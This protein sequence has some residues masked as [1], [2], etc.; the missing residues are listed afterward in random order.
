MKLTIGCMR[1]AYS[2]LHLEIDES[3]TYCRQTG[4]DLEID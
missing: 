4:M 3:V 1:E 2:G